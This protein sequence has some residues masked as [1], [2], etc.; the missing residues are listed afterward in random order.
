MSSP[1]STSPEVHSPTLRRQLDEL[2]AL[3]QQM[4]ELPVQRLGEEIE[5]RSEAPEPETP[6]P[7][8]AL[9]QETGYATSEDEETIRADPPPIAMPPPLAESSI[10][11]SP[12]IPARSPEDFLYDSSEQGPPVPPAWPLY[13]LIWW[14][15]GF[16]KIAGCLGGLG[17]WLRGSAGRAFLASLGLLFLLAAVVLALREEIGWTR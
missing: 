2:D 14:D 3:L 6:E 17:R 7:V 8:T 4:L 10:L 12:M 5:V 1:V 11:D 9:S 16:A 13:P 15:R